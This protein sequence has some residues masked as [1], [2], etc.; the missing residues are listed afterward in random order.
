[1]KFEA[2]WILDLYEHLVLSRTLRK[3]GKKNGIL[4]TPPANDDLTLFKRRSEESAMKLL[5]YAHTNAWERRH[6][7]FAIKVFR[8]EG[9]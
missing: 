3:K 5:R 4:C 9:E 2:F 1:M 7:D 6:W 8:T